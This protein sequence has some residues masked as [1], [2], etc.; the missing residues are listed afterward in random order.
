[1]NTLRTA[2]LPALG[3]LAVL[4]L[5]GCSLLSPAEPEAPETPVAPVAP[6]ISAEDFNE[7]TWTGIDSAEMDTAFLFNTDGS[8]D[9][10]FY[11]KTYEDPGDTWTVEGSTLTITIYN[12]SGRGDATYTGDVTDTAGPITLGLSFSDVDE[13]RTLTITKG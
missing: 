11:G 8:V 2:T 12:V 3:L 6:A 5:S 9:A 10:T 13:T 7:T 1:M 4:A